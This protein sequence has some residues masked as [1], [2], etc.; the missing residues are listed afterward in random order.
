MPDA[1]LEDLVAAVRAAPPGPQVTA[2]VDF[3][4]TVIAGYSASAFY[5]R[6]LLSGSVGVPEL[7]RTV[8]ASLRGIETPADFDAFLSITLAS[9]Q[10]HL[11]SE[12]MDHARRVFR[13]EVAGRLHA[14]MWQLMEAH[15]ERGHRV[16]LASSATRFQVQPMAEEIGADA[17]L[18][19]ELEEVE[20]RLTGRVAGPSM[21]GPGK[22]AAVLRDAIA[23]GVDLT[24]SFAYSNGTEDVPFLETVS[25]PAAVSPTDHL[26]AV[27]HDRDWPVL[28]CAARPGFVPPVGD[29]VRTTAF[30]AAVVGSLGAGLGLGA[31]TRSRRRGVELSVALTADVAAAL[32]GAT[33]HL[34][35]AEHLESGRP[36]VFV[37][38]HTSAFDLVVVMKILRRDFNIGRGA[39]AGRRLRQDGVSPVIAPEGPRTP[40]PRLGS[41]RAGAFH[42]AMQ[43]GV[44]MVP[45]VISGAGTVLP[46]GARTL[47]PGEVRVQVLAPI[48]TGSWRPETVDQHVHDVRE[49][50]VQAQ[51]VG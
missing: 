27:A 4:G 44:P 24:Q 37:I 22:A 36:C 46:C 39:S 20:G 42:L 30:C 25:R 14:E 2:Y 10:G 23:H 34:D 19:T 3:D 16:V 26:R 18:C 15:R 47:H 40:T 7:V 17:V 32:A 21:W 5:R 51:A 11:V 13:A 41:F 28:V 12:Q 9:W 49:L 45:I 50:F 38:N 6:R 35:G 31:L 43:S 1:R 33:I 8:A 48:D 29:V